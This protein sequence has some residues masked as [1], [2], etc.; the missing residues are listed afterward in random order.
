MIN[1]STLVHAVKFNDD[2]S[3]VHAISLDDDNE[4]VTY[5]EPMLT[6]IDNP[7]DYFTQFDEWLMFDKVN[8]YNCC[9]YLDRIVTL[10][11]GITD[12]MTEKEERE[13]INKA[14]DE[15]ITKNPIGIFKKVTK[16][17]TILPDAELVD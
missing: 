16:S 6:T 3:I 11:G 13:L 17:V 12:E 15:I 10:L 4:S 8:G 2:S 14:I 5:E 7:Y 9:E 1:E